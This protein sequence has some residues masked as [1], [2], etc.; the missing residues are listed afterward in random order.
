VVTKTILIVEDDAA[1][2]EMLTEMFAME[3]YSV[4]TAT[5]LEGA[6]EKLEARSY[7][8]ALL[9][10]SLPGVTTSELVERIH[11]VPGKPPIVIFSAR[12]PEDL[13][14]AAGR[15]GAAAVLQKPANMEL[16]LATMARVVNGAA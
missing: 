10:L 11:Q 4:E 16:L 5:N 6:I 1:S 13:R 9:D 14:A 12:M 8:G 2:V 15:L 3:E 7:H